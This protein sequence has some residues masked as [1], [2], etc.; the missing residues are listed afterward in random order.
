MQNQ[1][2]AW[3]VG[4]VIVAVIV[5]ISVFLNGKKNRDAL[6]ETTGIVPSVK[7][8]STATFVPLTATDKNISATKPVEVVT[9]SV[10]TSTVAKSRSISVFRIKAENG[11]FSPSELVFEKG[12]RV[13]IE[14]TAAGADY[15]LDITPPIGAYIVAKKDKTVAFGFDAEN[16]KEGVY[17]F[18]CRDYCPEGKEMKGK[19]IIK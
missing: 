16:N 1:K 15:D 9:P 5:L 2:T 14:F 3:I 6:N 13:Q 10:G 19:I 12:Q 7:S 8:S 11:V 17:A 18:S 4:I